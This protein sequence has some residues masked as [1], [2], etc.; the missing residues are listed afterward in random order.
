MKCCL[1]TF[2][3]QLYFIMLPLLIVLILRLSY[4]YE[5]V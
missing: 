5:K 4:M 3:G 2:A 1:M